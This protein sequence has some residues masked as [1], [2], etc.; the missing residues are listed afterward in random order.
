MLLNVVDQC[1]SL[2]LAHARRKNAT[3]GSALGH[4]SRS[5]GP[6]AAYPR[7]Q[8]AMEKAEADGLL[9]RRSRV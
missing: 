4:R 7:L 9:R 8:A 1:L 6:L 5:H 2:A 3:R